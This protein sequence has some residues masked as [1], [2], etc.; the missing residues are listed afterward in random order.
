MEYFNGT[1][2]LTNLPIKFGN[3]VMCFI[4]KQNNNINGGMGYESTI[5]RG[6]PIGLPIA[7]KYD[8]TG[9]VEQFEQSPVNSFILNDLGRMIL[10]NV[11]YV[12]G[13]P[14]VING[15]TKSNPT[16][17]YKQ[18]QYFLASIKL[19]RIKYKDHAG[20]LTNVAIV[21]VLREAYLEAIDYINQQSYVC[22]NSNVACH[23]DE[24]YKEYFN[25]IVQD[26]IK[27]YSHCKHNDIK[28]TVQVTLDNNFGKEL[29]RY[30]HMISYLIYKKE[31]Y[32]HIIEELLNM[33]KL[34]VMLKN[35]RRSWSL[36]N[37]L[38]SQ[39]EGYN[40]SIKIAEITKKLANKY[41]TANEDF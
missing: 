24:T 27:L 18:L 8:D 30:Q 21:L 36:M 3:D 22:T 33:F 38:D 41:K 29:E 2:M 6:E 19:N 16:L 1:C 10:D 25:R 11:F 4:L 7:G 5:S 14:I 20:N 34:N 12:G 23:H 28:A 40:A 37:G 32:Q 17:T 9:G 31:K 26:T 35:T 39:W 15:V 13:K